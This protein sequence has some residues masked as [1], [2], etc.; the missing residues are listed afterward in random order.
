MSLISLINNKASHNN[1]DAAI[2]TARVHPEN[3]H[4]TF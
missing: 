3:D 4:A 1:F 2:F